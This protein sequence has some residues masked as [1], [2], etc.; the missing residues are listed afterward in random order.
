MDVYVQ[1][2]Q[3]KGK[4]NGSIASLARGSVFLCFFEFYGCPVL[5]CECMSLTLRRRRSASL[6]WR[7]GSF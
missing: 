6:T 3:L 4:K 5:S 7:S 2:K 1:L